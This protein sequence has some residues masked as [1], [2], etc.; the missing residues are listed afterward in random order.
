MLQI[1]LSHFTCDARADQASASPAP[2][3]SPAPAPTLMYC[4]LH[5]GIAIPMN[6]FSF[7][8]LEH[9]I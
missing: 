8:S 6:L 5:S 3:A 2:P 9:P 7:Q 4:L 1:D